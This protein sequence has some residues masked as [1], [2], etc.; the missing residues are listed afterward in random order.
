M[1]A[2]G[3][4]VQREQLAL[5]LNRNGVS[6]TPEEAIPPGTRVQ[7]AISL[8]AHTIQALGRVVNS[9]TRKR[10]GNGNGKG[11][12]GVSNGIAF[13]QIAAADQDEISKFLFWQ[14]APHEGAMLRLTHSSQAEVSTNGIR[15]ATVIS[16]PPKP[17]I[18][19]ES[20]ASKAKAGSQ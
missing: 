2:K 8:P 12:S 9:Q 17:P 5:N 13:E 4:E 15:P 11:K 10:N 16:G 1:D 19:E 18:S 6:L 7:M 14:I 20:K 3:H